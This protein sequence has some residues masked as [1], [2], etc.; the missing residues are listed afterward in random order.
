VLDWFMASSMFREV[1][2]E[3]QALTKM[4]SQKG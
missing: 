4:Q 1:A 3:H 2:A